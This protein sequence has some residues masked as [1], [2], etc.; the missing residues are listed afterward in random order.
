MS[1]NKL[2]GVDVSHWNRYKEKKS[3]DSITAESHKSLSSIDFMIAKATQ[4]IGHKDSEFDNFMNIACGKDLLRG[5]YHFVSMTEPYEQA[6]NF[7]STVRPYGDCL[8][9]LDFED[10]DGAMKVS[11]DTINNYLYPLAKYVKL[12]TGTPPLI[13]AS[14]Y[15]FE[16]YDFS[17]IRKLDCGVW[18]AKWD[19]T[20]GKPTIKN[21]NNLIAIKQ[22]TDKGR[23]AELV[24]NTDMN[25]AY[26][27]KD[28]WKKYANPRL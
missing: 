8:L 26:M 23:I 20:E 12:M 3:T 11:Q 21:W 7:V 13:Y 14:K 24:G 22:Y 9:A 6:L 5:A 19:N 28:V 18:V 1:D 4:G 25:V 2:I 10:S 16:S 27:T 17:E 15:V